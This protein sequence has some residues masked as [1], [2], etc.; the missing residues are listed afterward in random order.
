MQN[1]S[2]TGATQAATPSAP[3]ISTAGLP[4]PPTAA[5][6]VIAKQRRRVAKGGTAGGGTAKQGKQPQ[7]A[8][9][10]SAV[11]AALAA[12]P[13]T[14]VAKSGGAQLPPG[15]YTVTW[16]GMARSPRGGKGAGNAKC[17]GFLQ[18]LGQ[19]AKGTNTVANALAGLTLPVAQGG[20]GNPGFLAY[21]LS[22]GYANAYGPN[23]TR[24][25][26]PKQQA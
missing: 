16:V 20:L 13:N 11:L 18:A 8:G 22:R 7:A 1:T 19:G 25:V 14:T 6:Q 15:T 26:P 9:V 2:N 24:W 21:C 12:A 3:T 17:A 10:N 5:Q 23:G 4:P